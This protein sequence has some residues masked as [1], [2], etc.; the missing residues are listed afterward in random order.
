[1]TLK[2]HYITAGSTNP[3]GISESD[4]TTLVQCITPQ[5]YIN[6]LKGMKATISSKTETI[7]RDLVDQADVIVFQRQIIGPVLQEAKRYKGKKLLVYD[8]DDYLWDLEG[9][10]KENWPP[11][12]CLLLDLFIQHCDLITCHSEE[13]K[14]RLEKRF[15]DKSVEYM[16]PMVDFEIGKKIKT[17][18]N[19][20]IIRI[21]WF[22][23]V[24]HKKIIDHVSYAMLNIARK[25]EDVILVFLGYM[26]E[27]IPNTLQW[28]QWEYYSWVEVDRFYKT[29]GGLDL[30]IGIAPLWDNDFAKTR[31]YRKI[32]DYGMFK[33]AIVATNVEPFKNL[34]NDL[35][36]FVDKKNKINKWE[37]ALEN[38]IEDKKFRRYLQQ[39]S[40]EFA[41][42]HDA[43]IQAKK[44]IEVYKKY[45]KESTKKK[46]KNRKTNN[47]SSRSSKKSSTK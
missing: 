43:T 13:V 27:S 1:M 20:N 42:D 14:N 45:E 4:G 30:H 19:E 44:W 32:L 2:I 34:P 3:Y 37:N 36:L 23:S 31:S 40:Y 15:P 38:V 5:K 29:L 7:D 46:E 16:P 8:L 22:G 26:P 11:Q 10:T 39:K 41:K 17:F 33:T 25:N 47:K 6:K 24:S 28:W 12:K 35:C 9:P 21:G 18:T